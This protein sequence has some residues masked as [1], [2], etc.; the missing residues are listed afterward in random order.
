M[1]TN[2]NN[3]KRLQKLKGSDFEIAD[4]QPDIRGWDVKDENGNRI[5]E[6][7]ELIFDEQSRKVRYMVL[8]LS[9]NK[10]DLEERDVLVPIGLAQIDRDDDDILLPGVTTQ[11]LS[12]LPAYDEDNFDADS[13]AGIRNVFAGAGAGALMAG[14]DNDF[15]EHDH[16]N[17]ENLYRNRP[18]ATEESTTIPVVKE[19]MQIGKREV[20]RGG[21]R[22][23]SR[24][25]EK[26]VA[27]DVRLRDERVK[28]DRTS[29]DRPASASDME[30][31]E[32][33][34]EMREREEVPV[35]HKEAR[36]VEEIKVNK[37]V[38]EREEKI[39]GSVRHTEVDINKDLKKDDQADTESGG[40]R[41]RW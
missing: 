39:S 12:S 34:V 32:R 5:G 29:V 28:V 8:D 13:E 27:E 20:Q 9:N 18:Q 31:G 30:A 17:E 3:S 36:I 24:I 2:R 40:L 19:E 10:L 1:E 15:Y 38:T 6:V 23:R 22:L 16:F 37:E 11:Q 26:E 25:V 21:I 14:G 41:N 4:G 7:D 33:E 35:V